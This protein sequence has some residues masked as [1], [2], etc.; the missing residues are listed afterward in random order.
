V[1]D[2]N[3]PEGNGV[4]GRGA[5][6]PDSARP[7]TQGPGV[8]VPGVD[9]DAGEPASTGA[10]VGEDDALAQAEAV[11]EA[12]IASIAAE[13]DDYLD[14]LRRLQ[15]DFE[16]Y[17]KRTQKQQTE[18]LDRAALHLVERLLPVLDAFDLALAH[19]GGETV[20]QVGGVLLDTLVKEGLEG[21]DPK[22]GELFDPTVHEAVVHEPG[23]TEPQVSEL[24]RAGYR[25]KGRL[26]RAAMV[27]V[28]G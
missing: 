25:W 14:A 28:K 15:A 9:F 5:G 26:L 20:E 7:T 21:I 3:R 6:D 23:D 10:G 22:P 17:K 27:K 8:E 13:R 19:G 12:D 1:T 4:P 24:L 2:P 16:N 18:L 11:I